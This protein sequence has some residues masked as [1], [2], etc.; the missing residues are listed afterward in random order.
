[1]SMIAVLSMKDSCSFGCIYSSLTCVL[2][3]KY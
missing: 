1:M 3:E 2:N